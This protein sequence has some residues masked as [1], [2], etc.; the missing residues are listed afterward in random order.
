[1]EKATCHLSKLIGQSSRPAG[2]GGGGL[3]HQHKVNTLLYINISAKESSRSDWGSNPRPTAT[4]HHFT[5]VLGKGYPG[6]TFCFTRCMCIC[7]WRYS[8]RTEMWMVNIVH[9]WV[10]AHSALSTNIPRLRFSMPSAI[11]SKNCNLKFVWLLARDTCRTSFWVMSKK[12]QNI[13]TF[14]FL[15]FLGMGI[16]GGGLVMVRFTY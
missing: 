11:Q 4:L 1:M 15:N 5:S 3:V 8:K 14:F 13:S 7:N 9:I 2:G 6:L 12:N 16:I 10:P